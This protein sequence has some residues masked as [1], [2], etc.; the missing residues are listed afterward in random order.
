[1]IDPATEEKL[2]NAHEY[3]TWAGLT[4]WEELERR[5]LLRDSTTISQDKYDALVQLY[6]QLD[7]FSAAQIAGG[8]QTLEGVRRGCLRFIQTFAELMI[9]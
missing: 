1:M 5:G 3:A 2:R 4:L 8:D 7:G 6:N 9:K